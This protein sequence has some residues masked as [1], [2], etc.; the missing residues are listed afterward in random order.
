MGALT[1]FAGVLTRLAGVLT[2]FA[3]VLTRFVGVLTR[4]AGALT[5]FAGA[6]IDTGDWT[7]FC[8]N[9]REFKVGIRQLLLNSK[10]SFNVNG[11]QLII[12]LSSI[13]YQPTYLGGLMSFKLR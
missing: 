8:V 7:E 1:R 13:N 2:R 10:R 6:H 5:R 12:A 9:T 4:F 3:G 11:L